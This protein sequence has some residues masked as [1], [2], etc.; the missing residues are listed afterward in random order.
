MPGEKSLQAK[1][2]TKSFLFN[3]LWHI[4]R[5]EEHLTLDPVIAGSNPATDTR[6]KEMAKCLVSF[7]LFVIHAECNLC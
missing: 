5:V 7:V 2:R 4:S 3:C 6:R 1:L